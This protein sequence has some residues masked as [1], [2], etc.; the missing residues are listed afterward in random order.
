MDRW[1]LRVALN[2]IALW[3]AVRLVPDISFP[4]AE[5]FPAED[6]W[7]LALVALLFGLLNT[8]LKPFLRAISWPA[9]LAT[10]GL[11][12]WVINAALLLALA[13]IADTISLGLRVGPFPPTL[14]AR[15]VVAAFVA[16]FV[17][18]I[19]SLLLSELLPERLS[20]RRRLGL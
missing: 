8:Y 13:W 7:K 4:A 20:W 17:I 10:L 2:A 3:V 14:D 9:R 12:S 15:A 18:S 5:R 16:S 1:L 11:F 6:W 19:V